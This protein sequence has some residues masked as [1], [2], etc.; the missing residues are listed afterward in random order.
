MSIMEG[1]NM[2][3]GL[4]ISSDDDEDDDV[5]DDYEDEDE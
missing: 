3:W 1:R 5:D 4:L 2:K